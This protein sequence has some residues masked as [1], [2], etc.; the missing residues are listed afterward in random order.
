LPSAGQPTARQLDKLRQEG[1]C[2]GPNFLNWFRE[3]VNPDLTSD[4]SMICIIFNHLAYLIG[5]QS[6]LAGNVHADLR[7]LSYA[8]VVAK[9]FGPYDVNRFRFRSTIF[10]ASC[11]LA[12]TANTWVITRAVDAE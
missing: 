11:P 9:S 7:Q 1:I 12:A 2:G 8:C 10:Q 6:V 4:L 3:H 5:S